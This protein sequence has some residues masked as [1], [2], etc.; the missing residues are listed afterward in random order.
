MVRVL[1]GVSELCDTST[2]GLLRDLEAMKWY[3]VISFLK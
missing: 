3:H 2:S 1:V